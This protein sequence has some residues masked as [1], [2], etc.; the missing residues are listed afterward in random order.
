MSTISLT[1]KYYWRKYWDNYEYEKIP[2][3]VVYN[4]YINYLKNKESFIEIGGFPG[5]N[6]AYFYKNICKDVSLL[7][8]YIDKQIVSK[9]EAFNHIP[10]DT[11]KCI[12]SDFFVFETTN[13]YDIVFSSGFI[14]H[15]D[16]TKDVIKRHIDL[17]SP[18]GNVLIILPNFRGLNG[19]LQYLFDRNNF[20][21]HNLNSMKLNNL[22]KIMSE[23]NVHNV[24][25]SYTKKP[26]LW[27]EPKQGIKHIIIR[28]FVKLCSHAL[29]LFP[30]RCRLLSPYIIV[31]AE[32]GTNK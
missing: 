31:F 30:I 20:N 29:K 8:F 11:I 24:K 16:D 7:D 32:Y 6:A 25:I 26:M 2:N 17:L 19:V 27:L 21:I 15:F 4:Q 23:L 12:E 28:K 3:K 13:K 14:E 9:L 22:W 1:D 18:N 5:I 10:K